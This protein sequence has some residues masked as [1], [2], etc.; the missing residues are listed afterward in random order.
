MK[1]KKYTSPLIDT[2]YSYDAESQLMY[3]GGNITGKLQ[4]GSNGTLNLG[5]GTD[6]EPN[7]SERAKDTWGNIWD[8]DEDF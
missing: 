7:D 6:E 1:K 5:G 8:D 3:G 2:L 4:S